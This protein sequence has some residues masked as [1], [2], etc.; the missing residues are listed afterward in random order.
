M[1]ATDE[2]I[3][4]D[5]Q[6]HNKNNNNSNSDDQAHLTD[7]QDRNASPTPQ[8]NNEQKNILDGD[9]A[10]KVIPLFILFSVLA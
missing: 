5:R 3:D 2:S 8:A 1:A 10:Q 4:I 6:D 9:L 7:E